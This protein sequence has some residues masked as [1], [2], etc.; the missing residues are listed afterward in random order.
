MWCLI[1]AHPAQSAS[2]LA[3]VGMCDVKHNCSSRKERNTGMCV[4][5]ASC[6][7]SL[8][9]LILESCVQQPARFES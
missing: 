6:S 2:S 3:G 9:T 1:Y 8:K 7:M 4:V 5:S